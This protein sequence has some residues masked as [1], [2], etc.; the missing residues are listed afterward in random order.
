MV[1][2]VSLVM[3]FTDVSMMF[4]SY[5]DG[6]MICDETIDAGSLKLLF[7]FLFL[8]IMGIE[9]NTNFIFSAEAKKHKYFL[10]AHKNTSKLIFHYYSSKIIMKC[11]TSFLLEDNKK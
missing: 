3:V 2:P 4:L 7:P 9:D 8:I 1:V 6:F 11:N 10:F 5:W